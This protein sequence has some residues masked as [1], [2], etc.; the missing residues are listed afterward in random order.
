MLA[1]KT[2]G[3]HFPTKLDSGLKH[4]DGL[5]CWHCPGTQDDMTFRPYKTLESTDVIA[6]CEVYIDL[7]K[8]LFAHKE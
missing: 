5:F 7:I 2:E 6:G 1:G 8:P 3:M 4:E